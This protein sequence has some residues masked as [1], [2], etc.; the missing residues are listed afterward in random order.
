[1]GHLAGV[2]SEAWL[3]L[4]AETEQQ[5]LGSCVI[6]VRLCPSPQEIETSEPCSCIHFTNYSILIGTNKFYEIDMKQYTLDGM[7]AL[8]HPPSSSSPHLAQALQRE[9]SPGCVPEVPPGLP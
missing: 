1:M 5:K 9:G 6:S 2:S 4:Q 8:L 3:E 7:A